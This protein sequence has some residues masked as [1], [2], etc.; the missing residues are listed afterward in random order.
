[1]AQLDGLDP[2]SANKFSKKT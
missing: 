1:M 2:K